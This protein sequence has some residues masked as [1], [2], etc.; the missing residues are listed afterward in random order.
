MQDFGGKLSKMASSYQYRLMVVY[1]ECSSVKARVLSG[2][3]T[4]IVSEQF[5]LL[6]ST[7]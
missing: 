1:G 5:V 2:F 6:F 4:F 3:T 7:V